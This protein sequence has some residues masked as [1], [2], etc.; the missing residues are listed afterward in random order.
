MQGLEVRKNR[1]CPTDGRLGFTLIELLVVIAIIA[2]LAGLLLPALSKAKQKTHQVKC[3]SNL[4][5]LALAAI[6]YQHDTGK[7][8]DYTTVDTLWMKTRPTPDLFHGGTIA[9]QQMQRCLI[10]RHGTSPADSSIRKVDIKQRLP[11]AIN[12]S[13]ADG[14]AELS[15]LENLWNYQWHLDYF[16]PSVRP[17]R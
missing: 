8:I 16:P 11:G 14:H 13:F 17:G 3:L 12:L 2:I 5:Q 9:D 1:R 10:A 15:R 4:K 7:P 6:M